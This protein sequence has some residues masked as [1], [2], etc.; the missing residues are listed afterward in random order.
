MYHYQ[1]FFPISMSLIAV[2]LHN[3]SL[4]HILLCISFSSFCFRFSKASNSYHNVL[5]NSPY[6]LSTIV[7]KQNMFQFPLI[8]LHSFKKLKSLQLDLEVFYSYLLP[9][10]L[11]SSLL[12]PSML[13][14]HL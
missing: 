12:Y 9:Y 3:I 8:T 2:P 6:P 7:L 5:H 4:M 11:A 1:I 14:K 10:P 13:I